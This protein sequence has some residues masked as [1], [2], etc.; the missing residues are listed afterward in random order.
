MQVVA[1]W[2]ACE[3]V[4]NLIG[5]I[6]QEARHVARRCGL[7]LALTVAETHHDMLLVSADA[8]LLDRLHSNALKDDRIVSHAG[9]K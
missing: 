4:L 5:K 1:G 9:T 6:E 2:L 8:H 3:F 7:Q